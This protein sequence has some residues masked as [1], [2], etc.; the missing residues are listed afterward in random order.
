MLPQKSQVFKRGNHT[1]CDWYYKITASERA[2]QFINRFQ[3]AL[4]VNARVLE[5][6]RHRPSV[7]EATD[8][9]KHSNFWLSVD[10]KHPFPVLFPVP[11]KLSFARSRP[12]R[13]QQASCTVGN[14][15][16]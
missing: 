13:L 14:S 6:K 10:G 9:R 16:T 15:R 1:E 12:L 4:R 3:T 7:D 5:G 2:T 11:K 8:L